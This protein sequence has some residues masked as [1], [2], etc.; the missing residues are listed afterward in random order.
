MLWTQEKSGTAWC[1]MDDHRFEIVPIMT[2]AGGWHQLIVTRHGM[3]VHNSTMHRTPI[4]VAIVAEGMTSN[5]PFEEGLDFDAG[6]ARL[7]LWRATD[8]TW[9]APRPIEAVPDPYADEDDYVDLD[10]SQD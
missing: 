5:W 7:E 4:E 9:I 8:R 3:L 10:L 2:A 1:E 6:K